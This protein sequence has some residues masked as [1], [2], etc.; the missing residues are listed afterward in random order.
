MNGQP[1]VNEIVREARVRRQ[2][3][4]EARHVMGAVLVIEISIVLFVV[5]C[6]AVILVALFR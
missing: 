1:N 4:Q 2:A 5:L 3:E 6:S